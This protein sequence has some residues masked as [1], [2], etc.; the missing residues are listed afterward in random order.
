[1]SRDRI[2]AEPRSGGGGPDL[3][4]GGVAILLAA[5]VVGSLNAILLIGAAGHDLDAP[6]GLL[7]G[8]VV[9]LDVSLV[10]SGLLLGLVFARRGRGLLSALFL[11][12]VALLLVAALLRVSGV[13]LRP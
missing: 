10:A 6:P 8:L 2:V 5:V 11:G 13:V 7:G 12:N 3:L 9:A 4:P 1:M